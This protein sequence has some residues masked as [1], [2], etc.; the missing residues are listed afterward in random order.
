M[1]KFYLE[2]AL[3]LA[4]HHLVDAE[5]HDTA[6]LATWLAGSKFDLISPSIM[7]QKAPRH[8][9]A[10]ADVIKRRIEALCVAGVL[11]L[12]GRADINGTP[13]KETYRVMR[14]AQEHARAAA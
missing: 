13:F 14:G 5:T 3:R 6:A 11:E 4:G 2:E 10:P 1:G 7:Q 12:N 8:L 9:R